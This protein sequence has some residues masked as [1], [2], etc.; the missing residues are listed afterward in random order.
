M[1]AWLSSAA[2]PWFSHSRSHSDGAA[3]AQPR[4]RSG[5]DAS[6]APVSGGELLLVYSRVMGRRA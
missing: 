2:G 6:A 4:Q 5:V 3:A 1:P